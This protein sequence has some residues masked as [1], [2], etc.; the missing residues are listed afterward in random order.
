MF[1][2]VGLYTILGTAITVMTGVTTPAD[3]YVGLAGSNK[4]DTFDIAQPVGTLGCQ[5][6]VNNTRLFV[7]HISSPSVSNDHP[8][9]NHAGVKQLVVN[10][11]AFDMYAGVSAAIP[12]DQ[13]NGS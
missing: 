13:L 7:E 12:S 4:S 8:G 1:E 9:V 6:D 10:T 3:C 11:D 5:Y 2:G